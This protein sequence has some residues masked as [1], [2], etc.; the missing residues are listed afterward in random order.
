MTANEML[1]DSPSQA[2]L[3]GRRAWREPQRRSREKK[4][5]KQDW[6]VRERPTLVE[7]F[8]E[9]P[10]GKHKASKCEGEA[11]IEAYEWLNMMGK[12]C[13]DLICYY[14][15]PSGAGNFLKPKIDEM[16]DVVSDVDKP[17]LYWKDS[18]PFLFD[19]NWQAYK[20][21]CHQLGQSWPAVGHVRDYFTC[22]KEGKPVPKEFCEQP[23][24]PAQPVS[25]ST[26]QAH[27]TQELVLLQPQA[28]PVKPSNSL[29]GRIVFQRG[30]TM[31]MEI[32]SVE[33]PASSNPFVT[34]RYHDGEIISDIRLP[35]N[36]LRIPE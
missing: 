29:V 35:Y 22:L 5:V 15:D 13:L 1:E 12:I 4:E 27:P 30:G 36:S 6:Q 33:G 32:V 17:G 28:K 9:C 31:P 10:K 16:I 26:E 2:E 19:S 20:E 34:C 7:K 23:P 11:R 14:I 24:A 25:V 3:E 18:D 8:C 21:R